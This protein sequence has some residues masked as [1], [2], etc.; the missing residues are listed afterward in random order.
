M[1]QIRKPTPKTPAERVQEKIE[2]YDLV[3]YGK[4]PVISKNRATKV[5]SKDSRTKDFSVKLID[6]DTAVLNH[7]KE[8]I[9]PT[10][11]QNT[12]LIEV[13]VIYAYPERWVA[14]QKDG[15][16]RDVNNKILTP[17]IVVNRTN[18]EKVRTIGRNLDGNV[19][20]NLHIFQQAYTTKN[21]YD[22][23]GILNNRQPV[24]EF[25]MVAHPD[26]VNITYDL[27]I[28]TNFVEQLNRIIESIQYAENSYWGDKNRYYFR[29]NA[30]SFSTVNSYTVDEERTVTSKITLTLHGY[31][32]PDTVNAF[33][34]HEMNFVSKGTVK[35]NEGY[36]GTSF[37]IPASG[38]TKIITQTQSQPG[39][40]NIPPDYTLVINYLNT[41]TTGQAE[42]VSTNLA[43]L[44]NK[45]ILAAPPSL[46]PTSKINFI[47][48]VNGV[49][50]DSTLFEIQQEGS[51]IKITFSVGS[52]VIV[53]D[54]VTVI[55]KYV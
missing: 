36:I 40:S 19:A 34:S 18:I 10:I 28:Y 38:K 41:N 35:F 22:N 5:S 7:I 21:A 31:L 47:V 55:G 39:T 26:Y 24:K 49:A 25:K 32:I 29:V 51:D 15:Y 3:D 50:V 20:Q 43:Y 17:V 52:S 45:T 6:L 12:E 30:N 42:V 13:P 23:F 1:A 27:T 33:M 9:K 54:Y 8:N 11:Y 37:T 16:L 44:R 4:E 53:G 2:P 48:Y 46:T 14:M